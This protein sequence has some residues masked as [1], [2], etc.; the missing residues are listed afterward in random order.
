MRR[1]GQVISLQRFNNQQVHLVTF[2]PYHKWLA[3]PKVHRPPTFYHLLGVSPDETD[4]EVIKEAALRQTSH[5]RTYQSGQHAQDCARIL[6]EIGRARSVLLDSTK[7]REY[8]LSLGAHAS[9]TPNTNSVKPEIQQS[10]DAVLREGE[11][12]ANIFYFNVFLK[13]HPEVAKFFAKV[14]FDK[15]VLMLTMVLMVIVHHYV[16][17]YPSTQRYLRLLGQRHQV[18]NIDRSLYADFTRCLLDT[19]QEFHGPSWDS[20]LAQ[21]WHEAISLAATSMLEG[22]Q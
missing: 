12:V 3:I 10:L 6:N 19:L 8:D 16:G 9:P 18:W 2:D 5:V 1:A 11:E 14:D 21:Q 13:R 17:S 15:Q 7:R 22:Y 20:K 4:A